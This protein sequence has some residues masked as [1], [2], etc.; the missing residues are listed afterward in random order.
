MYQN[1]KKAPT[2]FKKLQKRTKNVQ[3]RAKNFKK[4]PKTYR[5][6][7]NIAK[8]TSTKKRHN[9]LKIA[10][11]MLNIAKKIAQTSNIKLSK[12]QKRNIEKQLTSCCTSTHNSSCL[13]LHHKVNSITT[14]LEKIQT[15]RKKINHDEKLHVFQRR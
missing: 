3:K 11:K 9:T 13:S 6:C 10:A 8:A 15:Q 12:C 1:D 5:K 14:C 7:Q 2:I 4:A